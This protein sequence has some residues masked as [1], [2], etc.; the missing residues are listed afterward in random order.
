MSDNHGTQG[1]TLSNIREESSGPVDNDE[2][3]RLNFLDQII[4]DQQLDDIEKVY[5]CIDRILDSY[6]EYSSAVLDNMTHGFGMQFP[7]ML[8]AFRIL[9]RVIRETMLECFDVKGDSVEDIKKLYG[10]L[11]EA[12]GDTSG[13][14]D[15]ITTNYD[16][17]IE[18]YCTRM[19]KTWVDG[20]K[21][22]INGDHRI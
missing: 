13:S 14:V 21:P 2:S 19:S 15:I 10:S 20:F 11:L 16:N 7:D 8:D 12:V 22:S 9:K 5:S 1:L 17:I 18:T 4:H 3:T 6:Q